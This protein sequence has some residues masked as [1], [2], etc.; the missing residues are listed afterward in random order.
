MADPSAAAILFPGQG[1]SVAG[2]ESLIERH[3]CDLY[4]RAQELLGVDPLQLAGEST[5]YAQPAIF[6]ASLAG[7]RALEKSGVSVT[8]FAG[9]SLGELT[10]L[11]AAGVFDAEDGLRL[12]VMRGRLMDEAA[13]LETAGGMLAI[14]KGSDQQA[15]RLAEDCGVSVANYNAPGQVVLSGPN[16]SLTRA[17]DTAR[18]WGLRALH[19]SVAGAFHSPAIAAAREPFRRALSAI[20]RRPATQPVFSGLTAAPFRDEPHELAAALCAPVRWTDTMRALERLHPRSFIDVGPDE[21][22]ARLTSRNLPHA[23][24]A[25]VENLGVLA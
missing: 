19:L 24:V 4:A 20:A 11:S 12:V 23:T 5:R 16:E 17:A 6:L 21:V 18:A 3:C 1:S 22:L 8:A 14:L 13:C 15:E 10:A 7:W 9:H 2:S 25:S